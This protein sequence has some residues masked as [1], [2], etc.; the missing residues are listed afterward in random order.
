MLSMQLDR[1]FIDFSLL[2]CLTIRDKLEMPVWLGYNKTKI[3]LA[4]P[5]DVP[6]GRTLRFF[7]WFYF[8]TAVEREELRWQGRCFG[9]SALKC[10]GFVVSRRTKQKLK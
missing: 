3:V 8:L 1:H 10:R 9:A 6:V 2:M 5:G 4:K 7:C